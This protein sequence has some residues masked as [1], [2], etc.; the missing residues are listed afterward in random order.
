MQ[1]GEPGF[2]GYHSE[3][4]GIEMEEGFFFFFNAGSWLPPTD[5]FLSGGVRLIIFCQVG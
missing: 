5:Y 3:S 1:Y 2:R 4:V